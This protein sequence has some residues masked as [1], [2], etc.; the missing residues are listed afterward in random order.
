MFLETRHFNGVVV[1]KENNLFQL[2]ELFEKSQSTVILVCEKQNL[3]MDTPD[4]IVGILT[5]SDISLIYQLFDNDIHLS[6]E[7]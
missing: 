6:D 4:D 7:V 5:N 2:I 3:E 1:H